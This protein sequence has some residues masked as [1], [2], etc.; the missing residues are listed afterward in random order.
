MAKNRT[1]NGFTYSE[2]TYNLLDGIS[3]LDSDSGEEGVQLVATVAGPRFYDRDEG[4]GLIPAMLTDR[5]AQMQ[6]FLTEYGLAFYSVDRTAVRAQLVTLIK[7]D[8]K[9]MDDEEGWDFPRMSEATEDAIWYEWFA[10]EALD[11]LFHL[12]QDL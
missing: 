11:S 4:T 10:G 9:V 2:E 3:D 1:T 12:D 8:L 5:K 7:A 6:E